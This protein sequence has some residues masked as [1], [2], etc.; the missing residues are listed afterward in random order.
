MATSQQFLVCD[1][2]TL[3][4]FKQWAQAI[5][6]FFATATWTQSTDTG[7]VNW[8]T[9]ASVPGSAAFVYEVWQ[10]NDG[11]TTFYVKMEYGNVSGTNC[12]SLRISIGTSTNGA[13]TLT[14]FV[15][16]P[17]NVNVDTFTA[18]S[19]TTQF[20]CDFSG[21]A[22]RI[23]VM[24]WRNGANSCQQLF[25]IERSVNSSGAY[26]SSY[27]TLWTVGLCG[28][29]QNNFSQRSLPFGIGAATRLPNTNGFLGGWTV[30]FAMIASNSSNSAA[31]NGSL[32][33]DT[34]SPLIGY[35]DFPCTAVGVGCAGD[36]TEGVS[37][38]VTLYGSTRTYMPSK[39][40]PFGLGPYNI[41]TG[42]GINA[43]VCL[44]YD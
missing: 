14:G 34:P 26:T 32:P 37:F 36:L 23:G 42:S 39:S 41:G 21:A 2:S 15:I 20:E 11:L 6:A 40:G 28:S 7:Q 33:F 43:I 29:N 10:P 16:G 19:T 35:F 24:M 1:S 38:S 30:R 8:S 5:S 25:A 27:V 17:V 22:G 18:P 9:I 3:A 44:R 13:G 31:F 12:P 4:N